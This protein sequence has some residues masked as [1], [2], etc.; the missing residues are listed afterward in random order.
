MDFSLPSLERIIYLLPG[1][2]IGLT[3]HEYAHGWMANR[4]GDNTARNY[5]RLTLNPVAHLDPIGLLMLF[6]AGFGW[7]KPVPV[8]PYNL[9]IDMKQGML[10]VAFAGPATNLFI[11]FAATIIW[12][13]LYGFNI[14]YFDTFMMYAIQINVVL[15]IFNLLPIPPLDGSRILAGLLPGEHAWLDNLE[16]YGFLILIALVFTGAIQVIYKYLIIPIV[17]V[18]VGIAD[19][20][21]SIFRFW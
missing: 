4:L 1:I 5:G 14:P 16:Q 19:I 2:I 9:K 18:Y 6:F 17:T 21:A 15:A 10:L 3:F 11:A 20:I 13:V 8:N 7:A 12:G